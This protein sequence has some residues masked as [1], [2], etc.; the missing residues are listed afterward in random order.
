MQFI[1]VQVVLLLKQL[2]MEQLKPT[3]SKY[4]ERAQQK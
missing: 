4:P 3:R 2:L 1:G